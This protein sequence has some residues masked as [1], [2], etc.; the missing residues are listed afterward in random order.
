MMSNQEIMPQPYTYGDEV[1]YFANQ[2][3]QITVQGDFLRIGVGTVRPDTANN[4]E[5][6]SYPKMTAHLSFFVRG[7]P[8]LEDDLDVYEGQV[9]VEAGYQIRVTD[10]NY[11][12]QLVVLKIAT[13]IMP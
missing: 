8:D 7:R 5:G 1:L 6:Q 11:D 13:P 4:N 2:G 12:E 10:L 9:I 3:S